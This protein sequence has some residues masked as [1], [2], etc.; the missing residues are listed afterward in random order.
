MGLSPAGSHHRRRSSVL[1]GAG[2]SSLAAPTEQREDHSRAIGEAVNHKR[3]EQKPLTADDADVSDLSSIAE[4]VEMDYVSSDDELHDDEETGL[5]AKQ[6]RQR[7]R[8][9]KQ[10]RQLDARIADVKSSRYDIL[11]MGLADRNVVK[12]L[13]V[14]ACLI[15]LWYFFS[16]SISVFS[17]ASFILWLIPALRPRHPS[18]TSSG[19]PFRN[20]H[21]ASES[22][23]IL[24]KLFYLTRLVPC[25]AATSLDI[26]LGNMS[27][28]F[29]SLTF[30]TM[31][32]SS[33]LAFVLLFAFIFRLET[34][35]VKLIFIIATM[36]VGV[37]MMVAGETAFN[38]VGFALVIASAFFSGFRWGLTQILLLRHPATSNPFSTLF[39]LTPVMFFSLIIIA[40]TV[41]GPAKI[42]DGFAA[43]SETHGGVFAVFLLI[44]PGV[45]AFCMISAEFA[46]LKRSSV[47]TL[48]ICGIF[49]EVITISAAGFVF[50]DQLTAVNIAGLLITIASIGCY[51][52]MKI[53]KM[54]SEARRGTWERSPNL[55]SESD[56]SGRARSRSRGTYHRISDP[57]TSIVTP[58]SQVPTADNLAPVD[59]LIGDR[60][61]FQV[62]ASGASSNIHGLTI[63]TG[64]LSDNESRPFSPRLAGPSPL[65][66]AP[67]VVLTA[68]SQFPPRVG[69]GPSSGGNLQPSTDR[70]VSGERP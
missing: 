70:A 23:P 48:S 37:V 61:S 40:L 50:H 57:E 28:K 56:D 19:S 32:K 15:L 47:V 43:L 27:L 10:R 67:P 16:L 44:F 53:S 30:L 68:D 14:N 55:D 11:S 38:A 25:G 12:R 21:D 7:R 22:T 35:S 2:P 64:N 24:T 49:K 60:R 34:P 5:T 52:Y 63:S 6:R 8:R 66:S 42:A 26:G 39:F 13:L 51:N 17:L 33:A 65:K 62:R 3:D 1:T 45:L 54:R 4:S 59:G 9:R 18:S 20:S 46:L 31:C 41:E 29:I 69:R 58:V 36:T